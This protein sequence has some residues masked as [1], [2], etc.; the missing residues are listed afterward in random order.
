MVKTHNILHA[1]IAF[2]IPKDKYQGQ[3]KYT[4]ILLAFHLLPTIVSE[5]YQR[6]FP[7]F[8]FESTA[9]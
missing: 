1:G 4:K 6:L 8:K 9:T 5:S 2:G 7:S 3:T